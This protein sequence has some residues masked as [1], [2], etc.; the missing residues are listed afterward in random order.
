MVRAATKLMKVA[1]T[2]ESA[3]VGRSSDLANE[4]IAGSIKKQ[5]LAAIM[6][7]PTHLLHS[8]EAIS[9]MHCI[10]YPS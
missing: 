4:F 6:F 2:T 7:K 9:K 1:A 8:T 5:S 3:D 10:S